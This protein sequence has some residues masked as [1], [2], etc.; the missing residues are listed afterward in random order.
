[1][2]NSPMPLST[3]SID[4]DISEI[5]PEILEKYVFI[6]TRRPDVAAEEAITALPSRNIPGRELLS[7]H[8]FMEPENGY[9]FSC[10]HGNDSRF[11]AMHFRQQGYPHCFS[12]RNGYEAIREL[13]RKS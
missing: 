8:E 1:M 5:T 3:D 10:Y 9:I 7:N 11:L 12:L 6:D 2:S 4:L 13:Q